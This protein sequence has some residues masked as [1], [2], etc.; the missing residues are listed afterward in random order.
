LTSCLNERY[1]MPVGLDP[2]NRLTAK[3]PPRAAKA[4]RR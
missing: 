2:E 1:D 3:T 4:A